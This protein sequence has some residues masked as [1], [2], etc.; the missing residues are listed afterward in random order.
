MT[1]LYSTHAFYLMWLVIVFV[2]AHDGCLVLANRPTMWSAEQNPLGRWL[3]RVWGDDIWL[4]LAL[5]AIGTV[6]V[7]SVL[8]LFHSI[9]PRW[10]CTVCAGIALVQLGLLIFLYSA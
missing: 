7:A 6:S 1:R 5:K 10:A 8:L 4:F 2:S 3:I 9:R